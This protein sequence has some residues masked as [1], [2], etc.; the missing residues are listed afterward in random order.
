MVLA[1][2]HTGTEHIRTAVSGIIERICALGGQVEFE[3]RLCG[4]SVTDGALSGICYRKNGTEQREHPRAAVLAIG[5]SARD[6]FELLLGNGVAMVSKPFAVGLR[7]EHP[8][9]MINRAQYGDAFG[10]PRLG[11]AEV[12]TEIAL[13]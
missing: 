1:K 7:I 13:W 6:T 12:H 2:P 11:A 10:H 8:R 4:I 3:S 5:H 9:E